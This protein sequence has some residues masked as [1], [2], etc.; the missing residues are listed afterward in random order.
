MTTTTNIT[1]TRADGLISAA[2]QTGQRKG[3]DKNFISLF[4]VVKR[5]R[6]ARQIQMTIYCFPSHSSELNLDVVDPERDLNLIL[7]ANQAISIKLK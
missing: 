2:D 7:K 5:G 4:R 3:K 1:A 6:K